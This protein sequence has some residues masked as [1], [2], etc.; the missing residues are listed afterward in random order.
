MATTTVEINGEDRDITDGAT[1]ADLAT[2]LEL[3]ET[4]VAIAVD[5]SVIPASAWGDTVLHGGE[6]IDVLTAVQ[7]G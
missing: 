7:G 3:P 4:G 6:R 5:D 2:K 1:L